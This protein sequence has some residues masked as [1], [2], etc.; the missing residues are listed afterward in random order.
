MAE[1]DPVLTSAVE[2]ERPMSQ[3]PF[4]QLESRLRRYRRRRR[5]VAVTASVLAASLGAAG[6]VVLRG[7]ATN[8]VAVA[9]IG[10]EDGRVLSFG[11]SR[12]ATQPGVM[13][14]NRLLT[15]QSSGSS[16]P[17]RP[18]S[19]TAED[20]TH[21]TIRYAAPTQTTCFMLDAPYT[22]YLQ[23][24]SLI[25]VTR[26]LLATQEMPDRSHT[27]QP[28]LVTIA[29]ANPRT[30]PPSPYPCVPQLDGD[31]L[32]RPFIYDTGESFTP[33]TVNPP[34]TAAQALAAYAGIQQARHQPISGHEEA[35]WA[36]YSD[37]RNITN[38]VAWA[39][40]TA[41]Q[42]R[43]DSYAVIDHNLD[44]VAVLHDRTL[45]AADFLTS[46]SSNC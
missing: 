14:R 8:S 29:P 15:I 31:R 32:Q 34:T 30:I 20:P 16:C 37:G 38:K 44:L 19:V 28:N 17:A 4:E 45:H 13:Y 22:A 39:I 24:P 12:G 42:A 33:T 40:Y 41:P 36:S 3:P 23:L 26:P 25:D 1:F 2:L 6:V 46:R 18:V 21:V 9:T 5:A 10:S 11:S 43:R 7:T 35:F 27:L